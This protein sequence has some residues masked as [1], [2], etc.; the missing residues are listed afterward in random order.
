MSRVPRTE[1]I[2]AGLFLGDWGFGGSGDE[3]SRALPQSLPN[4]QSPIPQSLVLRRDRHAR[5]APGAGP[6]AQRQQVIADGANLRLRAA[7]KLRIVRLGEV[8]PE[9]RHPR[10]RL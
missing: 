10:S 6:A 2:I 7:A 3:V 9:G 5:G 4:P 8:R 1:G